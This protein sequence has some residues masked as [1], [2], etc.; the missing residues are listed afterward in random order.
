VTLLTLITAVKP[1]TD[2]E[3]ARMQRN[4]LRTWKA[5]GSEVEVVIV[6]E[7]AGAQNA[8]RQENVRFL[9]Q[10]ERT[11]SG[12]PTIRS[13]FDHARAASDSP[14][15]GYVNADIL[16]L[17]DFLPA[18]RQVSASLPIFVLVSQ[19]WDLRLDGNLELASGWV[20]RLRQRTAAEARRHPPAGSD[21]F[22]FPRACYT[23]VPPFAV[24]R[25]GWDNWMIYEARRRRWPVVD[26][27]RA[28]T[29][30]HQDHDYRHLPGGRSHHRHPETEENVRLAG[31]RQV[32]L[33]L[34][35][36]DWT[37][38]GGTPRPKA[39]SVRGLL[40]EAELLPLLRLRSASVAAAAQALFRPMRT[41]RAMWGWLDWKARRL[42]S[43]PGLDGGRP[44]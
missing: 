1:F 43:G 13:I 6:G 29:L 24:G 19:R 16:L 7:E 12:T 28:I 36:A 37:F 38:D 21:M 31:G 10:V 25:A 8:A 5:L 11:A 32:I 3:I 30:I 18:V 14:L 2:P 42:R 27:S 9:P 33:T 44:R 41:A 17:D 4:A 26:A 22:V 15:L 23:E 40:R 20:G 39:R 34:S 35:D